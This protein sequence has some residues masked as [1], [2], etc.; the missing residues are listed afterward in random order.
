MHTNHVPSSF[1]LLL[2][3]VGCCCFY[4]RSHFNWWSAA[5]AIATDLDVFLFVFFFINEKQLIEEPVCLFWAENPNRLSVHPK[6]IQLIHQF[7]M[8]KNVVSN[9]FGNVKFLIRYTTWCKFSFPK[10]VVRM[11][12]FNFWFGFDANTRT[13]LQIIWTRVVSI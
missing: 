9:I 12:Q 6:K 7:L 10:L 13:Y 1:V 2:Q 4:K 3:S 8:R 11:V 5:E